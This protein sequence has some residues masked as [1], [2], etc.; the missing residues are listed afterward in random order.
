[1]GTIA[2]INHISEEFSVSGFAIED[3]EMVPSLLVRDDFAATFGL[4]LTSG[5]DFA[6]ENKVERESSILIN[7]QYAQLLGWSVQEA[8][9]KHIYHSGWGKLEIIGIM[10]NF[11]FESLHNEIKPLIIKQIWQN[12]YTS[13]TDYLALRIAN[14]ETGLPIQ[15]LQKT[16]AKYA[17]ESAFE[18]MTLNTSLSGIYENERATSKI[19]VIFTY[20]AIITACLGLLGLMLLVIENRKKE[21]GIR[22]SLGAGNFNLL[23]LLCREHFFLIIFAFIFAVPAAWLFI[24]HWLAN[25]AYKKSIS[26]D[27]ILTAGLVIFAICAVTISLQILKTS[28]SNPT[29]ILRNE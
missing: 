11:N 13:L 1:M 22:K 19:T 12:R 28:L 6:P 21:I 15:Y 26:L 18:F 8:I 23:L 20:I 14:N 24:N 17:P 3:Q 7:E 27:T 10:E 25:F 9:G 29:D 4:E 2:G 5:H 16:W